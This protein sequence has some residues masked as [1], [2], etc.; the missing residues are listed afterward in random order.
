LLEV[1]PSTLAIHREHPLPDDLAP[2]KVIEEI[3]AF[4]GGAVLRLGAGEVAWW[5]SRNGASEFERLEAPAGVRHLEVIGDDLYYLTAEAVIAASDGSIVW[6]GAEP[7][8]SVVDLSEHRA[9][10]GGTALLSAPPARGTIVVTR[11]RRIE[12][13]G[14]EYLGAASEIVAARTPIPAPARWAFLLCGDESATIGYLD[15]AWRECDRS[16]WTLTVDEQARDLRVEGEQIW[17][18]TAAGFRAFEPTEGGLRSSARIAMAGAVTTVPI[19]PN[20]V[21]LVGANELALW[22]RRSEGSEPPRTI[23]HRAPRVAP[24]AGTVPSFDGRWLRFEF[25]VGGG[26]HEA[27]ELDVTLARESSAP[28]RSAQVESPRP[29]VPQ[30]RDAV[31]LGHRVQLGERG[32]VMDERGPVRGV[33]PV[34]CLA[35]FG[36]G[37]AVGGDDGLALLLPRG[38]E[39]RLTVAA[40]DVASGPI[41]WVVPWPAGE[42]VIYGTMR[43]EVGCWRPRAARD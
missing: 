24:R 40:A 5:R 27:V 4:L 23:F 20:R 39:G 31:V 7:P 19:A 22:R 26:V 38:R 3:H 11:G 42:G 14:G 16:R 30:R 17:V 41:A 12:S 15:Q 34:R 1:D 2:G 29:P 18:T 10:P 8:I 6:R 37:I 28:F 32:D 9:A 13:A 43:G 33:G 36:G 21:G 35:A 25:S